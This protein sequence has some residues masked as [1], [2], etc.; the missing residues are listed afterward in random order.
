MYGYFRFIYTRVMRARCLLFTGHFGRVFSNSY[1]VQMKD[2][3]LLSDISDSFSELY[4]D[5]LFAIL[6]HRTFRTCIYLRMW[7]KVCSKNI[8][9]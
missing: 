4:I 5:K 1:K 3:L 7:R 2:T 8:G 6:S 9:A